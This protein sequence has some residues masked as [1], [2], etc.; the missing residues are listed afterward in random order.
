MFVLLLMAAGLVF[1][2]PT[3]AQDQSAQ[4]ESLLKKANSDPASTDFKELRL[5]F[6]HSKYGNAAAANEDALLEKLRDASQPKRPEGGDPNK[7]GDSNRPKGG[8]PGKGGDGNGPRGGGG[9][10][11]G[12]P[13][14]GGRGPGGPP[15]NPTDVIKAAQEVID[16]NFTESFAHATASK[17]YS[18]LK[19][20]KEAKFHEDVYTGL[21][22][23]IVNNGDG[24]AIETAYTVISVNEEMA[25][26]SA[27]S[28]E[29]KG[30][31]AVSQ[32][33]HNY[34]VVTVFDKAANQT[35]KIYFNTDNVIKK[36]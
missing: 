10:N 29:K 26:L 23:S 4:Y 36:P 22:N 14:G 31:E 5:A 15:I 32:G 17:A 20:T 13:G 27:Y 19:K 6:A 24:N 34:D 11:G 18:S 21:L 1:A 8:D 2:L 12:G 25:V 28:L 30:T 35:Y 9:G 3:L 7:A 16:L 33:G